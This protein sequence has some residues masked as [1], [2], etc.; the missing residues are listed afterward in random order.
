MNLLYIKYFNFID[1]IY[2]II[3][4]VIILLNL[5]AIIFKLNLIIILFLHFHNRWMEI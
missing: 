4:F 3:K 5:F 1:I 2:I